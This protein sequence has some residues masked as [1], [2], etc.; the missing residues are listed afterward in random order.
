MKI[1]KLILGFILGINALALAQNAKKEVLFTIDDKPYY[2]DEFMRVYNKNIDLVKDES[3]KDLN[4][5]LELFV[6]YKLKINKANKIGL[7][8]NQKYIN[9]LKSYR[10]Q[11]SKNYTS[12]TKV[13]KSLIEEAYNRS[14]KE[15]RASHILIMCD[16]NA[17]PADS[18]KAYN[19]ALDIRKKALAGEKFEDLAVAFSQDPSAKDNKGDL[20]YF[21]AFRMVYAFE[22]AAYKTKQGE[23]SMPVRT[24]F[25]Y[26]LVKVVD[27]RA[28]RG[29]VTVAHIMI[30]KSA[31]M[32]PEDTQKAKSTI[33]DIYT[34]LKQGESFESLASQ[35]SQD[36]S[37]SSKGG[38]L[39]RFG[40]GQLSS[41]EFESVAFG[42]VKPQ[43]YSEP[44]ESQYGWHIVKLIE[45][46]PL[47]T[48]QESEREL[49]AKIRKD[50]RSRLIVNSLNAKLRKKYKFKR[51]EKEYKKVTALV[52]DKYYTNEW[53]VTKEQANNLNQ[54]FLTIEDKN[55][56]SNAFVT[57]LESQQKANLKIKPIDKLVDHVYQ[58]FVDEQLTTYYNDNLEK[59]FPDF[60]NVIEEYRD[61][62]L[63]FDLMEKE[64]WDKAKQDTLGLKKYYELNKQ[65]YQWKNRA[66]VLIASST[67]QEMV[68]QAAKLLKSGKNAD[69]IKAALNVKDVVNIM[70]KQEMIEEGS[71][72]FSKNIQLKPGVSQV[73]Q[74]KEFYFVNQVSK[75]LP[76][77]PKT[78]EESRGRAIND[79]Q[80]YLEDNWVSDLKKEFKV[81]VNQDVFEKLKASQKK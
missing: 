66:D 41:E 69:Q 30:M 65:K 64:I 37:S 58:N 34:K 4:Q 62:L 22:S 13:T 26:H 11:L 50:D 49:D 21:S 67:K 42:L 33:Q 48:F 71:E 43:S 28:N 7:Q 55:I 75:V 14:Q 27:A 3:Q 70:I 53:S 23:V 9:E 63:L 16:E 74:E 1:N 36:K 57:V 8:N 73:Y 68:K 60:A 59:E 45:K 78:L 19:Q 77:G 20:G 2:T 44:F 61:G 32:T 6:G 39:N 72:N 15:I 29:E 5:Y 38:V 51:N 76:A 25:G 17:A 24:R 40:S 18:L 31:N 47:K 52:T 54:T 10:G 35:F 56:D 80:Q 81:S 12:D 79:Y 46:H